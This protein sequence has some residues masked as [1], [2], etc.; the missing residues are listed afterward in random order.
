MII[1]YIEGE[2]LNVPVLTNEHLRAYSRIMKNEAPNCAM[3]V[4]IDLTS[5]GWLKE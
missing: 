1:V 5:I 4:I 2:L 3:S